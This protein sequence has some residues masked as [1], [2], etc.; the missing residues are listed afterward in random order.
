MPSIIRPVRRGPAAPRCRPLSEGGAISAANENDMAWERSSVTFRLTDARRQAL[1]SLVPEPGMRASPTA[2]I[3]LAIERAAG[4]G[5]SS[6][7]SREVGLVDKQPEMLEELRA[8]L[9]ACV[10]LRSDAADAKATLDWVEL[11]ATTCA[12]PLPA[13]EPAPPSRQRRLVPTMSRLRW[14]NG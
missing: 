10:A 1:L 4:M 12:S 3:D 9:D 6:G 2:A 5:A 8:V 7:W 14:V 11:R 13:V